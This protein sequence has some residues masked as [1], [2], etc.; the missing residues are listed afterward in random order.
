MAHAL[1]SPSSMSRRFACVGSLALEADFRLD[2][3]SRYADEG[4]AAHH[5]AS[6]C[7]REGHNPSDYVGRCIGITAN[8]MAEFETSDAAEYANAFVVDD[9]MA[10]HIQTY[11]NNL[12][13]Y[14]RAEDRMVEVEL[15]LDYVTGEVGGIGTADVVAFAPG[16]HHLGVH[17]LK[18]GMRRVRA[19]RNEQLLTYALAAY[20]QFKDF[21]EFTHVTLMIHQP[22]VSSEPDACTVT[23][24]DLLVFGEELALVCEAALRVYDNRED[25]VS[26]DMLVP[27]EDQCFFCKAKSAC[28]ALA[29]A[30]QD[31]VGAMFD[32]LDAV[33]T[34][35]GE[36]GASP[37]SDLGTKMGAVGL[38]EK[39]CLAVRAAVE[40]SLLSGTPVPGY[41][42][43][44]GR[45]GARKWVDS[46]AAEEVFRGMRI[47]QEEVY[48]RSLI[49]PTQAEKKH[50]SGVISDTQWKKILPLITQPEGSPSVAPESDSRP[51]YSVA[52]T[53]TDLTAGGEN[54]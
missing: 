38:V 33:E 5:L 35:V 50:A 9:A 29:K 51:T 25:G 19:E 27:G 45:R 43:V 7:L 17:D 28:P 15:P 11:I 14:S 18:Y 31:A 24:D 20:H 44:M 41:K 4:T 2:N 42:L 13:D 16:G 12:N 52:D 21:A 6:V 8:G 3:G 36:V 46:A 1:L 47:K 26:P 23:V 22:R 48:T 30:V 37:P 49:S 54:G 39:W 10:G 40:S 32:D 34:A 53:F